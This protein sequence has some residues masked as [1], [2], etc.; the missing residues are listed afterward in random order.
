MKRY[1]CNT[2]RWPDFDRQYFLDELNAIADEAYDSKTTRGYLVALL[3]YH[4]LT[5]EM[6]C[7]LLDHIEFYVQLQLAPVEIH[8]AGIGIG[9]KYAAETLPMLQRMFAFAIR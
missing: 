7:L 6:P 5:E 4:Q 2:E 9:L 8:K 1:E 3:I